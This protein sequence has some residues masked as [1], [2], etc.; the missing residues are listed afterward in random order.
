MDKIQLLYVENIVIRN[1]EKV[2]QRLTF[3]MQVENIGHTKEIDVIWAG[4]DGIWHTLA[5]KYSG[6]LGDD[7]EYWQA[8]VTFTLSENNSLPGNIEFG[9]RY[10]VSGVEF[11]DN[12]KGK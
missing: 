10:R 1:H 4:E 5:A 6:M 11:W 8:T 3:F 2:Q 9:I 12:K 7:K